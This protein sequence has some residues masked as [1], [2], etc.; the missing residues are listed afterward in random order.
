MID[1]A[2]EG[3]VMQGGGIEGVDGVRFRQDGLG[4]EAKEQK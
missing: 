2:E 4:E 1:E 3:I